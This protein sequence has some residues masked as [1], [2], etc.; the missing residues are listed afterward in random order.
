ADRDDDSLPADHRAEAERDGDD[1]LHPS[2]NERRGQMRGGPTTLIFI[3]VTSAT[4]PSSRAALF[5]EQ[6]GRASIRLLSSFGD[7]HEH[8]SPKKRLR[9]R[10]AH[11]PGLPVEG[12]PP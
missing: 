8:E 4:R 1:D 2:R 6:T 10:Q 12:A 3:V 5:L 9:D 7:A 11:G